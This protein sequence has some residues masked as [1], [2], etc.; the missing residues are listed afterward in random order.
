MGRPKKEK[1][2]RSDGRYEVK[3]TVGHS[4]DGTPI[5]K[6]FYSTI[7]KA[8]ALAKAEQY[9]IDSI[10]TDIT[11]E[12]FESHDM[13]FRQWSE[14]W[15]KSIQ[16]TVK[17]STFD[18]HY[19]AIVQN[20][21]LPAFGKR[22]IQSIRQIDVQMYFNG[23]SSEMAHETLRMHK[24]CL[25]RLFES[26]V[27]NDIVPKNPVYS[28]VINSSVKPQEKH[29]Y[30][31][32]QFDTV[33]EYCH[34]HKYGAAIAT[35]LLCGVSR[36]EL[37]GIRWDDVDIVNCI[38]HIRQGVTEQKNPSTGKIELVIGELKNKFRKRDIPAEPDL[39]DLLETL[40]HN[41]EYVFCTKHGKAYRPEKWSEQRYR[42]FMRDLLQK[43]PDIPAL[44][45]H[46]LRHTRATLLVNSGA[47]LYAVASM[48][49][50]A[51]LSMLRKHY[52]HTDTE[53]IRN[54]LGIE[55]RQSDD[56]LTT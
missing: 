46:E 6:S 27:I 26:A 40:P 39:I 21:L 19:R 4:F 9:K 51:D 56:N 24:T 13:T 31:Q 54:L 50:H 45:P 29:A 53:S 2:N 49:G 1:P 5:R 30:T 18:K 33:L 22:S 41:S 20:H 52:V 16:G 38:I 23:K 11:G 12:V 14:K 8:D 44:S 32:E 10:V 48:L 35:M 15:L 25:Y 37:L 28:I 36:S 43:H 55:R 42:P 34:I 7:S 47:N 17:N 3:V